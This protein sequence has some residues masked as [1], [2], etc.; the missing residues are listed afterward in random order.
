MNERISAMRDFFIY[1]KEHHQYRQ[2]PE[3]QYMLAE[4]AAAEG[5]DDLDRA[6]RRVRYVIEKEQPV[7]FPF[8]K[9]A[10]M[11]TVPETQHILTKEEE[12]QLRARHWLHE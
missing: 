1:K 4:Q 9:I 8:E 10:L 3:Y 11:R 7:V 5:L 2:K 12:E 6:V